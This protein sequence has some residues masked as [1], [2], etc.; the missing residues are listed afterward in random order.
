MSILCM[1]SLFSLV[2]APAAVAAPAPF[3]VRVVM[4]QPEEAFTI[5][6]DPSWAPLG[7]ARFKELV[8]A[9]VLND[10][11]IFRAIPNFMAQFG[12]PADPAVATVWN[13][14][15]IKDDPR[16]AGISNQRGYVT[17]A[18]AGPNTRSNQIFIN[19]KDNSFLDGQG[20]PPFGK[21]ADDEVSTID[22]I[23]K[24]YGEGAPSGRG[25]SQGRIQQEGNAYLDRDFPKL[26]RIVSMTIVD[27]HAATPAE[28]GKAPAL[29]KAGGKAAGSMVARS[30]A[31]QLSSEDLSA[32]AGSQAGGGDADDAT[33]RRI[34]EQLPAGGGVKYSSS[35]SSFGGRNQVATLYLIGFGVLAGALLIAARHRAAQ[36]G[37]G[38]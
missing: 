16:K 32:V 6:V 37:K 15:R 13:S 27:D 36:S 12:L 14:K 28:E 5:V 24:G 7:A 30:G 2:A 31:A 23:Y 4:A 35:S 17:F 3:K 18:M 11:R 1:L 19:F 10:V 20:F 22:T 26:T 25:P 9:K 38:Q 34:L 21:V 8:E 29:G 33:K